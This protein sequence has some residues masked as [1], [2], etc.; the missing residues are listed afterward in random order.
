MCEED[1]HN[2]A[3]MLADLRGATITAIVLIVSFGGF[4]LASSLLETTMGADK[5]AK[6]ILLIIAVWGGIVFQTALPGLCRKLLKWG[7]Q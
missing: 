1:R 7:G 2:G 5:L 3:D 4:S 6:V